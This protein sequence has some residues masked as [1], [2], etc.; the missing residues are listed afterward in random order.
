MD[1]TLSDSSVSLRLVE[2]RKRCSDLLE[3]SSDLDE[4]TLVE[5]ESADE[6]RDRYFIDR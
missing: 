2:I 4:L 1:H 3:D 6:P 5:P